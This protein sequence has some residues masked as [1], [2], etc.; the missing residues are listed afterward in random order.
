[1]SDAPTPTA[2]SAEA[3]GYKVAV[4]EAA[5]AQTAG[6]GSKTGAAPPVTPKKKATL[7]GGEEDVDG[8]AE[9]DNEDDPNEEEGDDLDA[10][11]EA[12]TRM[13]ETAATSGKKRPNKETGSP[14]P[15]SAKKKGKKAAAA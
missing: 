3:A 10:E 8:E 5:G 14:G 2:E 6:P 1:M 13:Q 9:D 15:V 11:L 7:D 12:L 4:A